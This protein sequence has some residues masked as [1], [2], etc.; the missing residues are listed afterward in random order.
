LLD[1]I[2]LA[3]PALKSVI[4]HLTTPE[5]LFSGDALRDL[6]ELAQPTSRRVVVEVPRALMALA[7]V[8]VQAAFAGCPSRWESANLQNCSE[9]EGPLNLRRRIVALIE[10]PKPILKG[11]SRFSLTRRESRARTKRPRPRPYRVRRPMSK[12]APAG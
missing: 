12:V 4:T 8:L 5:I 11:F 2:A 10:K 7:A 1:S 6:R 3:P 9:S